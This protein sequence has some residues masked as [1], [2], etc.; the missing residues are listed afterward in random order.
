MGHE[1]RICRPA[2]AAK[3]IAASGPHHVI[4]QLKN[5]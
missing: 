2:V 1:N 3:R 5:E 4:I